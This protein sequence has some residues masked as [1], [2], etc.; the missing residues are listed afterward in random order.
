[1]EINR[2]P[3]SILPLFFILVAASLTCIGGILFVADAQCAS[4]IEAWLPLYP[5]AEIV[6]QD[7]NLIRV[8]GIGT[9]QTVQISE[10]D[11]ETVKQFYRDQTIE[12]M[13]TQRGRGLASTDWRIVENPNGEGTQITLITSCGL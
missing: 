12:N 13:N 9:G 11:V 5:D 6:S 7:Y 4:D 8:R 1:L 2:K 3:P 10:D